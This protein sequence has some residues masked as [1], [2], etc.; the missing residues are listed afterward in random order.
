MR[1][2]CVGRGLRSGGVGLWTVRG[3]SEM[4]EGEKEG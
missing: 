1:R 2:E 3:V 4:D